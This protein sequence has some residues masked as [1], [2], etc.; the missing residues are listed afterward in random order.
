MLAAAPD[1][2]PDHAGIEPRAADMAL[3]DSFLDR[4]WGET[5]ASANTLSSYR[6]DLIIFARWLVLDLDKKTVLF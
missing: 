3:I 1:A 6:L 5:G 4:Y 2:T